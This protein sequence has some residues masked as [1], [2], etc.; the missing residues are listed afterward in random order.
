[1]GADLG[2]AALLKSGGFGRGED[3]QPVDNG[4]HSDE[5]RMKLI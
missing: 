3:L 2:I 1:M 4:P 5:S